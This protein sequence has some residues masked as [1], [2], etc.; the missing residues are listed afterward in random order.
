MYKIVFFVIE[1]LIMSGCNKLMIDQ[2]KKFIQL[3]SSL[4]ILRR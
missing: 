1:L 2:T 4:N 3:R